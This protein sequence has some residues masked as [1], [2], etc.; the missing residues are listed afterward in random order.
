MAIA[1]ASDEIENSVAIKKAKEVDRSLRRT[2]G[3]LTKIDLER[4]PEKIGRLVEVLENRTLPLAKGFVGVINHTQKQVSLL[5]LF[6][7]IIQCAYHSTD[8][9]LPKVCYT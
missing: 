2:I 4:E 1:T 5:E 8:M 6:N 9:P 3:V 7:K